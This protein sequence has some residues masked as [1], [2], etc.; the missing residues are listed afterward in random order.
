MV[1]F[2]GVIRLQQFEGTFL[3]LVHGFR[4]IYRACWFVRICDNKT[5]IKKL[6]NSLPTDRFARV[7]FIVFPIARSHEIHHQS[8]RSGWECELD[9][10]PALWLVLALLR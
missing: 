7:R 5:G 8:S 4:T 1:P 10:L 3:N 6:M 9:V 2:R